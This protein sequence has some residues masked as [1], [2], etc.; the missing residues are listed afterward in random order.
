M[1][2]Y[3]LNRTQFWAGRKEGQEERDLR[4]WLPKSP[5]ERFGTAWHLTCRAYNID[6]NNPPK[7]DR[8]VFRSSKLD[9]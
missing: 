6:P 7:I 3:K 8:T 5:E 2:I 9:D 4:R 1:S